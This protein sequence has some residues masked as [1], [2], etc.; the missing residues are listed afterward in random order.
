[1]ILITGATGLLGAHI[2]KTML[3]KGYKIRGLKRE[4]SDMT[5]LADLTEND[6][7]EWVNCNVLDM[8]GL[9][10][11]FEGITR[12]IHCAAV[13][14]FHKSDKN[15]MN[16][17]NIQGTANIVALCQKYQIEKLVYISS[18]A[19]L[20][21]SGGKTYID[22]DSKWAESSFNSNYANSK[23]LAELEVWRAQEEGLNTVIVNPSTILGP[24]HWGSSSMQIFKFVKEGGLFYPLGDI[25][26]VDVRD[27]SLAVDKLLFNDIVEERFILNAGTISYKYLFGLIA[28]GFKKKP[29]KFKVNSLLLTFAYVFGSLGAAL[30]GKRSL[31][32]KESLTLSKMEF[33]F[34]NDKVRKA[35]NI[36]FIPVEESVQW[37]CEQLSMK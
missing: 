3:A 11:A 31:I 13:V 26:Y 14:S 16:Q 10:Q 21:R 27:V 35:L 20:G 34:T 18:V 25:N 2:L 8:V 30:T 37:T 6:N 1:M 22:E 4:S 36:D 32:T 24:G 9:D 23:Y 5:E 28:T 33:L 12:V 7:L 15:L 19:A 17:V 29:P